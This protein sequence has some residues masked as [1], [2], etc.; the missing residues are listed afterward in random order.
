MTTGFIGGS[1]IPLYSRLFYKEIRLERRADFEVHAAALPALA[2]F[3]DL[4]F[5]VREPL[6]TLPP[7]LAVRNKKRLQV[8]GGFRA[9]LCQANRDQVYVATV[10]PQPDEVVA[11]LAWE[12]IDL[13]P[14]AQ[15]K[16]R[17]G[18]LTLARA[19]RAMPHELLH[20]MGI[21]FPSDRALGRA[22]GVDAS[23]VREPDQ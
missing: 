7:V 21:F 1:D 16:Q 14:A 20:R 5:A 13:L 9:W 15:M 11:R 23:R 22:F 3:T 12:E 10:G 18:Y 4:R 17:G 6:G 8:V 2:H 19:V